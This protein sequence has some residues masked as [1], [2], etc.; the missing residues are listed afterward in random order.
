MRDDQ[1]FLCEED[2]VFDIL[3][4]LYEELPLSPYSNAPSLDLALEWEDELEPIDD[5]IEIEEAYGN[6]PVDFQRGDILLASVYQEGAGV[7]LTH[8]V[9]PFL[10][11]YAN[12]YKAYGFQ[13][14]TSSPASLINYKVVI[15]DH[16]TCGIEHPCNVLVNI[17]RGVD[18]HHLRR[19]VGHIDYTLKQAILEKLYEIKENKDGLYTDCPLNDRID[20][21]IKNVERI[22]C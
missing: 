17:V 5:I 16:A 9:R 3:S 18:M 4:S 1:F 22:S 19:R 21:T 2:D 20:T 10:V 14:S 12:A 11:I 15:P 8:K 13:L 6:D 7:N